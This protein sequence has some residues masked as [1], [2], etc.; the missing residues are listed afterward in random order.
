MKKV[1][2]KIRNV[3]I[4][5]GVFLFSSI[6]KVFAL[7]IDPKFAEPALYGS[8]KQFM[9]PELYGSPKAMDVPVIWKILRGFII[10]AILI[11]GI[12]VYFKKSK[13]S[14][15]KKIVFSLIFSAIV[16]GLCIGINYLITR[17]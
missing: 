1:L 14:T 4:S 10:P 13:S 12:I 7:D 8:P 5:I 2:K 16:I 3:C 15:A 9:E 17:S 11:I 6:N